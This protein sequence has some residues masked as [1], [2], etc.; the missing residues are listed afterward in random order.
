MNIE[1]FS[2]ILWKILMHSTHIFSVV[3]LNLFLIE[4]EI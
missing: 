2:Q 1:Y 3:F 4:S